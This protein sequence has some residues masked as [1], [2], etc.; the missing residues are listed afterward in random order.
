[1]G[2]KIKKAQTRRINSQFTKTLAGK[3]KMG[4]QTQIINYQSRREVHQRE[5]LKREGEKRGANM[6]RVMVIIK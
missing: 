6:R 3:R 5:A 4:D 1:L 2:A